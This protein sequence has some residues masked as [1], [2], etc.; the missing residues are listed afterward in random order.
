M[1]LQPLSSW[2]RLS[3]TQF[4]YIATRVTAAAC[5]CVR[6]PW[7]NLNTRHRIPAPLFVPLIPQGLEA[8][9]T[10]QVSSRKTTEELNSSQTIF[11]EGYQEQIVHIWQGISVPHL[12]TKLTW[13]E[14]PNHGAVFLSSMARCDLAFAWQRRVPE[15]N[16]VLFSW[17]PVGLFSLDPHRII[18]CLCPYVFF[19]MWLAVHFVINFA[20]NIISV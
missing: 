16:S 14:C 19:K 17:W 3:G 11:G 2:P 8:N 1:L 20:W 18:T 15:A 9:N 4:S 6:A 12:M 5:I 13:I 10:E 7:N